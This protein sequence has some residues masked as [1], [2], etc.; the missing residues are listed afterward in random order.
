MKK[1]LIAACA[2]A[3]IGAFA[4]EAKTA[5]T[6][7]AE[8]PKAEA[9]V[10]EEEPT[11]VSAEFSVAY[12]SHHVS[13]GLMD[14]RAPIVTPA[15]AITFLDLLT[16]DCAFVMDTTR[17]SRKLGIGNRRWQY[18][19]LDADAGLDYTFSK[20]DY[21]FL[22]TSVEL[23][24]GY[25]YE[26]HPRRAK[27]KTDGVNGNPDTQFVTASI[28]LPDLLVVPT[29]SYERDIVRDNGTYLN[30]ELAHEFGLI[31]GASEDDD[32]TLALTLAAAQG[33]GNAPRV[34]SYLGGT[35]S[36][37]ENP[38]DHA[39]LMDTQFTASLDWHITDWLTLSPY[40]AYVDFFFDRSI[41]DYSRSYEPLASGGHKA[42]T[43]WHV[44]WGVTLAASF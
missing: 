9:E 28:A 20:E 42:D 41:R 6:K 38:L 24:L 1:L 37:P 11:Y 23:G 10:T 32:P 5:E 4:D 30:L 7:P 29:F 31:D 43:S 36:D 35:L 33:F 14:T 13:Y 22:P 34:R 16:F 12:E 8:A 3:C 44:L 25:T 39:G 40:V 21:E 18:W 15:G 26:Y 17:Y 27:C 2:A 19:E